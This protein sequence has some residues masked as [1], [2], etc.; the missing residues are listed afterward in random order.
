MRLSTRVMQ[1]NPVNNGF[2]PTIDMEN[3]MTIDEK[4]LNKIIQKVIEDIGATFHAPLVLIGEKLGLFKAMAGQGQLTAAELA[5]RTGT[6]E[7]YV[8]EWLP[9]M[10]AGGYVNYDPETERYYLS[11]EQ[12]FVF[13]DES[14]P[15]YL[16]GAFQAATA[17]I[18]SEPK[19]TEAFRTGKGVGW[20]EHDPD[21][22]HGAE[23]FY[24]PIYLTNLVSAWIP[25]LD[26]VEEKL[27]AGALVADV[28]CGFGASTIIMARAYPKSTFIGFDYHSPSIQWAR[29]RASESGL[30]DRVR[31]EDAA[32]KEIPDTGYD[33]ITAFDCVHDMGDPVGVTAHILKCLKDDGTWMIVE[34]YAGD[35]VEE[36]FTPVG[37]LYYCASVLLCVSGALSQDDD[38]ALGGQAGEAR[39]REVVKKGG[40]T[41]FRRAA[42]TPFNIVYEVKP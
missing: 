27:K 18:R 42:E 10:A 29:K 34:P 16:A 6:A 12:A 9:S 3:S 23:R 4:K 30:S 31:F 36:N 8:A 40:F 11:E 21:F 24:K 38:H 17:A 37:R 22:F 14:S 19:I 20:H 35:S 2:G 28:G 26:G 5:Q 25:A 15:A 32:A 7:R 13:A 33:L 1:I 41:R 39:L